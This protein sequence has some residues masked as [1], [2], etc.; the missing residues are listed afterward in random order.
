VRLSRRRCAPYQLPEDCRR[1]DDS[2]LLGSSGRTCSSRAQSRPWLCAKEDQAQQGE[3]CPRRQS[4]PR[5]RSGGGAARASRAARPHSLRAGLPQRRAEHRTERSARYLPRCLRASH[6][7][8]D[9]AL[10]RTPRPSAGAILRRRPGHGAAD[11]RP[12]GWRPRLGGTPPAT[13][14]P[15]TL[16]LPRH[17]GGRQGH[18]MCDCAFFAAARGGR[19]RHAAPLAVAL[20]HARKPASDASR[21]G[22]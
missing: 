13:I 20:P 21:K 22:I 1:L 2:P 6:R 9:E 4:A 3:C 16:P 15:R 14:A 11:E 8:F 19:R 7:R 10:S 18:P 5:R 12:Q 17:S